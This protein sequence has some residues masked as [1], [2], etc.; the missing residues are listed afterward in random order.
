MSIAR[1]VIEGEEY[2]IKDIDVKKR[3]SYLFE[4]DYSILNSVGIDMDVRFEDVIS[5]IKMIEDSK[6]KEEF[7]E[8]INYIN[9]CNEFLYMYK[10][11]YS[12]NDEIAFALDYSQF[13]YS[14][15][16]EN[17]LLKN[18]RVRSRKLIKKIKNIEINEV[19]ID[20]LG[21]RQI[22]KYL[23]KID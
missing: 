22:E 23:S 13:N 18:L 14:D 15:I 12:P 1:K 5:A 6:I 16:P 10:V 7:K 20:S 11:E 19:I 2:D 3:I 4:Y 9:I 21:R 8:K 17:Y